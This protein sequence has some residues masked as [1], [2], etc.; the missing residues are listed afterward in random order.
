MEWKHGKLS[1]VAIDHRKESSMATTV[2]DLLTSSIL[3]KKANPKTDTTDKT[4]LGKDAFLQ[5]LAAQ[6]RYQDPL[7]PSTDTQFVSQLAQFSQLEQLQNLNETNIN[8]QAFGLVG[9]TV[10]LTQTDS[11][12]MQYQIGGKVDLV[13][14]S[15]GKTYLWMNGY[16]YAIDT[17]NSVISDELAASIGLPSVEETTITY[18]KNDPKEVKFKIDLGKEGNAAKTASI[19]IDEKDIED[20]YITIEDGYLTIKDDALKELEVGP[21]KVTVIFD[22]SSKTT[23]TG[24]VTIQ[25]TDSSSKPSEE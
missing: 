3:E 20:K 11:S 2:N 15:G 21:H 22:N 7:N 8:S 9:K 6:M 1:G 5:L 24:K 17:L 16:P 13:E 19:K 10:L 4:A 14:I 12:G 23:I 25:V 18:D